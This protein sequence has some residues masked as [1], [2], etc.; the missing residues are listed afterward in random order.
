VIPFLD[1]QHVLY[2]TYSSALDFRSA[3]YAREVCLLPNYFY[4]ALAFK[5]SIAGDY[6]LWSYSD[7]NTYGY[8]YRDDFNPRRPIMNRLSSDDDSCGSEQFHI[9]HRLLPNIRYV[10]VVT[11]RLSSDTGKFSVIDIG[12]GPIQFTPLGEYQRCRVFSDELYHASSTEP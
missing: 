5:V 3:I 10:L 1:M 4:E 9:A 11:T 6:N 12:P 7:M 8:L 2:P